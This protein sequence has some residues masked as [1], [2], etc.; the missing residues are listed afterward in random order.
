MAKTKE[1][2]QQMIKQYSAVAML[3][4]FIILNSV[5]TPNFFRMGTLNNIITQ[6][7]PTVLCGMEMTLV[8]STGGIDISVGSVM[9]LAGV[10]T[11]K[12]MPELAFLA[13]LL[14]VAASVLVGCIA[15]FYVGVIDLQAM[16]I[17][18]GLMLGVRERFGIVRWQRYLL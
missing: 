8:I 12:F 17:T 4:F 10:M 18:L 6:I 7:C 13:V 5:F 16:V 9:A 14:A 1:D 11:A 2:Y 3:L 15:G